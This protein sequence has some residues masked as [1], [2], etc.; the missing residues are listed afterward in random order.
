[1][2]YTNEN[3]SDL[4]ENTY[5]ISAFFWET[6]NAASKAKRDVEKILE[7]MGFKRIEFFKNAKKFRYLSLF[8]LLKILL[9]SIFTKK[10]KNSNVIFQNGTGIDLIL[11]PIIKFIFRRGKRIILIH[12]VESLRMG[13][14][15]D[16]FREK[17]VFSQFSH[18]ICASEN[19]VKFFEE[20]L[21]IKGKK[22][23]LPLFDYLV[24]NNP[25]LE[26]NIAKVKFPKN[27][28]FAVVFPGNLSRWKSEFLYKLSKLG[29]EFKNYVLHL[30]GK[31]FDGKKS[32]G[33]LEY[34]G[35]IAPDELPYRLFGH[36]GLVWDGD[37]IEKLSGRIG[38]YLKYCT[39]HK[40]S[41][42]IASGLP[43]ICSKDAAIYKVVEK[44]DIGFGVESLREIDIKLNDI[45]EERYRV[46]KENVL[47]LREKVINGKNLEEVLLKVFENWKITFH[48]TF[49]FFQKKNLKNDFIFL[50]IF[51]V[52]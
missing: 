51:N 43:V 45:T 29:L 38:E 40:F 23:I 4:L 39:P 2:D 14:K 28:K 9:S 42:Y 50:T 19:E 41:L 8:R 25:A 33:S 26:E 37:D 21:K 52:L 46:W 16:F 35:A 6:Y 3:L 47:N 27:S 44:Y 1:M 32:A 30:Y 11:A 20:D 18:I 22:F 31:G 49:Y 24:E 12:D 13:R 36:F 48:F 15:V 5:Y 34:K 10:Y 17:I 7:N